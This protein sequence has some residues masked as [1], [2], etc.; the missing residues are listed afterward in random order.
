M[1]YV[2]LVNLQFTLPMKFPLYSKASKKAAVQSMTRLERERAVAANEHVKLLTVNKGVLRDYAK[3]AK[4]A[5]AEEL[6]KTQF[7]M[8]AAWVRCLLDNLK[9]EEFFEGRSLKWE[10]IE[11]AFTKRRQ[12]WMKVFRAHWETDT[13]R[14]VWYT[15]NGGMKRKRV[16]LHTG[17]SY[18][19]TDHFIHD[20][21]TAMEAEGF[22]I[23]TRELV[24]AVS[25]GVEIAEN[26]EVQ[27]MA[28][29]ANPAW[30][31]IDPE[32]RAEKFEEA[33]KKYEDGGDVWYLWTST[34]DI[35][36]LDRF[37]LVRFGVSDEARTEHSDLVEEWCME[38]EG[39]KFG[40]GSGRGRV[41]QR[42]LQREAEDNEKGAREAKRQKELEELFEAKAKAA[43]GVVMPEPEPEVEV[44]EDDETPENLLE[45]IKLHQPL[46][47]EMLDDNGEFTVSV[48]VKY[49]NLGT[50]EKPMWVKGPSRVHMSG[51]D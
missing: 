2:C 41:T 26:P 51:F 11:E 6:R 44:V 10:E 40:V 23:R 47:A 9:E 29:P 34:E 35:E 30:R 20:V 42:V 39:L 46:V 19:I 4:R 5:K 27:F 49:K 43:E 25:Q 24:D 12:T 28:D 18:D 17:P 38:F 32:K 22:T 14:E 1:A 48:T 50:D 45:V 8:R 33:K 21:T 16:R 37:P 7:L 15:D 36:W 31:D 3:E 13:K